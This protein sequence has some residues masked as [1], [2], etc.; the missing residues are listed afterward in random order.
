MSLSLVSKFIDCCAEWYNA[1]CRILFTYF[2]CLYA[3]CHYAECHYAECHYAECH[4]AEY[5]YAECHGAQVKF[6][7]KRLPN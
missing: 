1:E 7:L 6:W 4:Y 5:R 3:E 2:E